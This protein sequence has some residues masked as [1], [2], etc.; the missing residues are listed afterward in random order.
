MKGSAL[1]SNRG[2]GRQTY[3]LIRYQTWH[4]LPSNKWFEVWIDVRRAL[5]G[6]G[7]PFE[8]MPVKETCFWSRVQKS[9]EK[10]KCSFR[11][12]W[13][14][15]THSVPNAAR[16]SYRNATVLVAK[17]NWYRIDEKAKILVKYNWRVSTRWK[18]MKQ[19]LVHLLASNSYEFSLENW[20]TN[21]TSLQQLWTNRYEENAFFFSCSFTFVCFCVCLAHARA[22]T[23]RSARI[24]W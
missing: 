4:V 17:L 24:W 1:S 16:F 12:N 9:I 7:N 22:A 13:A 5:T 6:N 8:N 11:G 21:S 15:N 2:G 19:P 18:R 10:G 14:I 3:D 23:H 20:L